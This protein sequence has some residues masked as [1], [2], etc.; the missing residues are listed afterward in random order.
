MIRYGIFF[1]YG[2]R[3]IRLPINPEKLPVESQSDN[4]SY[5]VLGIGDITVMRI[6]KQRVVTIDGL[7]PAR[8]TSQT[9]T[10][11]GFEPPEFYIDFFRKA[12]TEKRV[13]TYTP[14]KYMENGT[15]FDT[16]DSGF[17][18]T[19]ESFSLEERGGETGDFYFSL[20]IKEWR[21]YTPSLV[22][23]RSV[24]TGSDGVQRAEVTIAPQRAVSG[25]QLVVGQSVIANGDYFLSSY[26]DEPHGT[27]SNKPC[28]IT[29]IAEGRSYPIHIANEAGG[30][31]GWIKKDGVRVI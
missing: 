6:P 15:P 22:T 7:L 10:L 8:A 24:T 29:R 30:A 16:S 14:A 13:L 21:D 12:Q 5:N 1:S 25:G 9:L 11:R 28:V 3:V 31:L 17:K 27:A 19:V 4:Q 26:G 20:Q 18:C 2:G 23:T